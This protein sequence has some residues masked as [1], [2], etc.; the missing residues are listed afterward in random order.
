[1]CQQL[2]ATATAGRGRVRRARGKPDPVRELGEEQQGGPLVTGQRGDTGPVQG[3]DQGA[4]MNM[5]MEIDGG[6]HWSGRCRA[7]KRAAPAYVGCKPW[8]D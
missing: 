4:Q 7:P 8:P 3:Q 1:M 6:V 5:K 2:T